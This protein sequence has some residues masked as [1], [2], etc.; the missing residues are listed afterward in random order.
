M[1]RVLFQT[2]AASSL[3][4]IFGVSAGAQIT[5]EQ[6]RNPFYSTDQ[7]RNTHSL[8]DR[9]R[10]DL[11]RAQTNAYPNYLGDNSRFDIIHNDLQALERNWDK[12]VYDSDQMEDTITAYQMV[13]SD[14]RLKPHDRDVLANDFSRLTDFQSEYF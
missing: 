2:F 12:G 9:V 1:K 7:Y 14:N 10:N 13:L 4:L 3:L 11:D 8:F 6:I 5:N